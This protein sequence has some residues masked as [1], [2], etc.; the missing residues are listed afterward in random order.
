MRMLQLRGWCLK[1]LRSVASCSLSLAIGVAVERGAIAAPAME[2]ALPPRGTQMESGAEF[3][4]RISTLALGDRDAAIEQAVLDG[5]IPSWQRHL[6]PVR[7]PFLHG[8][9]NRVITLFVAPDYLAVGSDDDWFHVPLQPLTAQRLA[10]RLD[11]LLPTP[12]IVDAIHRSARI[13]L[14]PQ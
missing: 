11:C 14:P 8:G 1:L 4:R 5:N 12:R 6:Q 13:R 9:T 2:L 7:V 10:D 3:A